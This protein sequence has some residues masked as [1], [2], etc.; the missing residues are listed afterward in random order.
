MNKKKALLIT[1]PCSGVDRK[2]ISPSEIMENLSSADFD[3]TVE[4]T[5]GPNDATEIVKKMGNDHDIIICCGGD[6]TLNETINGVMTLNKRVPVGYIPSGSTND[7]A[8]T[9][10]IAPGV[11]HATQ[12]ILNNKTNTYDVG[13]FQ[14]KHFNYIAC[15]GAATDLSYSTP[16][17]WKNILGHSAYMIHGFI[18][19]LIPMIASFKPTYMKIEYDGGVIEDNVYYGAISNT[20][21]VAGLAKYDDVKLNDGVF[22]LLLVKGLKR[23]IDALGALIQVINKDYSSENIV[24]TKTKHLKITCDKK[25]PWSLD[26][27]FGGEHGDVEINIINDAYDIY[28][29]NDNLFIEK[30]PEKV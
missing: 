6:G 28:S 2:R 3:F 17:K 13:T 27:E 12:M 16:Q 1:N 24:F 21:S 30:T 5:K 29:D 18:I 11:K 15:F 25:I 23:N 4:S 22:E 8:T 14:G 26:G 10:G 9:L 20:T 19:R 7:L